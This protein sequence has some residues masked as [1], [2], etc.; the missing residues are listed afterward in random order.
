MN[1]E[2]KQQAQQAIEG[3]QSVRNDDPMKPAGDVLAAL[4]QELI[5]APTADTLLTWTPNDDTGDI[6]DADGNE[7]YFARENAI[8]MCRVVMAAHAPA[9]APSVP[10]NVLILD[11]LRSI[12]VF[13]DRIRRTLDHSDYMGSTAPSG[14]KNG[15]LYDAAERAIFILN[16]VVE[17]RKLLAATPTPA[18]APADVARDAERYRWLLKQAW[19]QQAADRFNFTDGGLQKRFEKCMDD[20][21]DAAIAAEKGGA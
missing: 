14:I 2:Q 17:L 7:Y 13:A 5:D 6:T 3:W 1:A 8:A 19:F 21:V 11:G 15:P 10:D 16:K 12:E 20:F 4:L 18:E 9:E